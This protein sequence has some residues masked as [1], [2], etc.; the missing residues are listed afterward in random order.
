MDGEFEWLG[1][2][3]TFRD[4]IPWRR[5]DIASPL[6]TYH[7][8]Y[9]QFAVDLARATAE[10]GDARYVARAEELI[11]GWLDDT[12]G[13]HGPGWDPYPTSLRLL[14]WIRFAGIGSAYLTPAFRERLADGI[15]T[16]AAWLWRRREYHL[17]GNHL[18]ANACALWLASWLLEGREARNAE[19]RAGRWLADLVADQV[20]DDGG[21]VERSPM[22]HARI[23]SDLLE[24]QSA[25][26]ASS[27]SF[28]DGFDG[29]V[30]AMS[31]WL[32][33][34]VRPDGSL[35]LFQDAADDPEL[36]LPA[37][38]DRCATPEGDGPFVLDASGYGGWR[39][40]HGESVI[41][42]A[43]R[44]SPTYQ[45]GHAHA[46]A[47]SFDYDLDGVPVVVDSG[48]CGY[49]GDPWREYVRSTRA[50]NTVSIDGED[51]SEMWGTFRVA[52]R[53]QVGPVVW[54]PE[55]EGLSFEGRCRG[56][57]V[58]GRVH[59]RRLQLTPGRLHVSDRIE[60]GQGRLESFIHLHP[61]CQVAQEE[62]HWFITTS[63]G[64]LSF[65]AD[66]FRGVEVVHGV[67]DPM[68]GWYCPAFGTA[69][70]ASTLVLTEPAADSAWRGYRLTRRDT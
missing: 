44:P 59:H 45:P 13:G 16:G 41:I 32:R 54:T 12:A 61:D 68:Q 25:A 10:T 19:A 31:R 57:T 38:L 35:H 63:L 27:L 70:P 17:Q 14:N 3:R 26:R 30:A 52:R 53:A 58:G 42:D 48:T 9:F 24:L 20:L 55:S 65:D 4:E 62:G 28:G 69:V 60:G 7:F 34:F 49:D 47:L 51:Q 33:W 39:R 23:L 37:L 40:R 36:D 56:V 29:H 46:G 66:G 43:G 2:G 64:R 22:Y 1:V 11:A 15:A 21:H 5:H 18:L 8:H 6:W 50:H 67:R